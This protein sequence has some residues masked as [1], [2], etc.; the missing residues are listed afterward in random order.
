[1]IG[2]SFATALYLLGVSGVTGF[3]HV[4]STPQSSAT[5][6]NMSGEDNAQ[7]VASS[8]LAA[9]FL[10]SNV[11]FM[12]P[13]LAVDDM[14][15]GSS[16]VISKGGRSGG[17]AG[18]R[19]SAARAP[20]SRSTSSNTRVIQRTTVIQQPSVYQSPVM[21]APPVYGYNPL[22]GLGTLPLLI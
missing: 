13:A 12:A 6:L 17:R 2:K 9:A 18:G 20:P 3:A 1:M 4:R 5:A 14:D 22:P 16:Q 8:F 19:S 11:A 21:M 15:F 10:L 7:K